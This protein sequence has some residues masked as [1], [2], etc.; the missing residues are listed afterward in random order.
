MDFLVY[1]R[2]EGRRRWRR[3]TSPLAGKPQEAFGA[4]RPVVMLD[5]FSGLIAQL[6]L[7]YRMTDIVDR[8]Q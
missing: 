2:C 7:G 6:A 5:I 4:D 1:L 3:H 8:I